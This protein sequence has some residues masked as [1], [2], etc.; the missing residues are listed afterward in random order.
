MN[1]VYFACRDCN[2]YIDAGYRWSMSTLFR[3]RWGQ[4]PLKINPQE[5][6]S[7]V[8]Y[9]SGV[10][11]NPYLAAALPAVRQF[12]LNHEAHD[13]IFGNSESFMNFDDQAYRYLEWLDEG[14]LGEPS[15]ETLC[16]EPRY[17]AEHPAL[18][19]ITWQQVEDY[20]RQHSCGWTGD[21]EATEVA[22]EV[23]LRVVRG[24]AANRDEIK[25]LLEPPAGS[26]A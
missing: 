16:L 7:N 4:F 2:N 10:N 11:E 9:W 6:L 22:R 17:F 5:V 8:E 23:F 25:R 19:Y 24:S 14:S 20:C 26:E 1:D 3:N 18:R 12:L 13:L 15:L 21:A